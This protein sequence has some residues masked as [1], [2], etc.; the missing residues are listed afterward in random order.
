M[1]EFIIDID[2]GVVNIRFEFIP[3]MACF[4]F[5]ELTVVLVVCRLSFFFTGVPFLFGDLLEVLGGTCSYSSN[6]YLGSLGD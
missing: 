4:V 6:S 3:V 1:N 5:L 2:V